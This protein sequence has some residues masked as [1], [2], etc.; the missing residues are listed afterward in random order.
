MKRYFSTIKQYSWVLLA[1]TLLAAIVGVV[2][3]KGQAGVYQA[4]SVLL[5]QVGVPGTTY[6]GAPAVSS[7]STES[8][9]QALN[10]A[11]EIQSRSVM[12][13]VENSYPQL[14]QRGFTTE[15]LLL[16]VIPSTSTTAATITLL[17]SANHPSDAILLAND[18]ANGFAA[19]RQAQ[20]QKQLDATRT[21]LQN[22]LN[23]L[24]QQKAKWEAAIETLPNNTVPAYAVDNNNLASVSTAINTLQ[25]QLDALPPTVQG[26][27]FVIQEATPVDVTVLPKGLIIVGVTAGVGLLVGILIMLLIIFLDNRL[28]SE[29]QVKERLGLAYLGAVS[30]NNDIKAT[31]TRAQGPSAHELADICANLRL[32]GVLPGQWQA[33]NGA[34]LLITSAQVAEGRTTLAAAL[35]SVAARGGSTVV[36][37]DGNLREPSTHLAF[38]MS[39]A[40]LGLSGLLKG[41]GNENVDDAV[42]RSSIPGVWVLPAGAPMDNATLLLEQ[43]MPGILKQ[44]RRKADLVIIDGPALL[45]GA[46]ASILATMVDGVAL[47]ADTRHEKFSLLMRAR[48]LMNSL[49]H[50]PAGIIM[51]RF[52][53]SRKNRNRY[54]ATAFPGNMVDDK[55]AGS[56]GD[57][58]PVQARSS[59]GNGNGNGSE[60]NNGQKLEPISAPQVVRAPSP[61]PTNMPQSPAPSNM[62]SPN[63]YAM[64][65]PVAPYGVASAAP[66]VALPAPMPTNVPTSPAPA[67]ISTGQ[68]RP[69]PTPPPAPRVVPPEPAQESLV[70]QQ[71][72]ASPRPAPRRVEMIPPPQQRSGKGE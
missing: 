35:S 29:E 31:P 56:L 64:S 30:N 21:N 9:G 18:V 1:C 59:N 12:Q 53:R 54:Y 3:S 48:E 2:V 71:P 34:V 11:A 20:A 43:R 45:S 5:V 36:V 39:S 15:D 44:L 42:M 62:P 38:G 70:A 50:K 41:T 52:A 26:D 7:T 28:R 8:L 63:S 19:Y 57:L 46:D 61:M 67:S 60:A 17:A 72:P 55:W 47:V 4:P 14:K 10:Y 32:T 25:V 33:P 6:P 58:L 49:A 16:D 69:S 23:S 65:S 68:T 13:Y 24:Q 27:V 51:N 22:Q 66:S 37:V 40:G